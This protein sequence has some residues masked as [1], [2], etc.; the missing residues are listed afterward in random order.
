MLDR[1]SVSSIKRQFMAS[2][3][4]SASKETLLRRRLSMTAAM[5]RSTAHAES[6]AQCEFSQGSHERTPEKQPQRGAYQLVQLGGRWTR[7]AC[8]ERVGQVRE[9]PRY[10]STSATPTEATAPFSTEAGKRTLSIGMID[11]VST[12]ESALLARTNPLSA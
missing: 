1:W 11:T 6:F 8:R 7:P 5:I 3:A 10:A 2:G 9:V 12:H 4:A